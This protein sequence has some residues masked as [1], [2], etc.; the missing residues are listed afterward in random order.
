MKDNQE[1]HRLMLKQTMDRAFDK[2]FERDQR[3]YE[4]KQWD[5]LRNRQDQAFFK[6][7]SIE[8]ALDI[9]AELN[10]NNES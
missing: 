4:E 3:E 6:E 2:D 10:K 8:E 1:K 9:V 7:F 5:N